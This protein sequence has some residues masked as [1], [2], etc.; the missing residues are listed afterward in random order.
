[1]RGCPVLLSS[2][3]DTLHPRRVVADQ[4]THVGG[5]KHLDPRVTPDPVGQ[6]AG[7]ALVE[8]VLPHDQG[9]VAACSARDTAA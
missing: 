1:V 2:T 7:H 8:R 4:S 5:G 9:Y 6:V 3:N